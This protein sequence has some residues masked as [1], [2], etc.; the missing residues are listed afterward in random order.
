MGV[1]KIIYA[2]ETLIDLTADTVTAE[3]LAE[4][5]TAHGAD[6]EKIVGTMKGGG[7]V[8]SVPPKDVNFWDY[9]GTCL[10]AYTLAEAQALTALPPLPEH[11][12]LICQG[13]NWTLAEVK[14]MDRRTDVGA[15]Y[16]TDDGATRLYL[17]IESDAALTIPLHFYQAAA[18]NVEIDWG[19]GTAVET[20]AGT[21][22]IS[23]SHTYAAV[24]DYVIRMKV[25]SGT[26]FALGSTTVSTTVLGRVEAANATARKVLRKV[27]YGTCNGW[28]YNNTFY[29]CFNLE[30]VT[31]PK[32]IVRINSGVFTS[33]INLKCAIVP[34]SIVSFAGNSIWNGCTTTPIFSLP[35]N[36]TTL[37]G[38]NFQNCNGYDTVVL[39]NG[40]TNIGTREFYL[41][42]PSHLI[43]P[44]AL[45][46]IN[47]EAFYSYS[48]RKY[49]FTR[50]T[51]VPTLANTNA[52]SNIHS[53]AKILVPAAS[54]D[55]WKAATNWATYASYI[56]GV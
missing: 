14:A 55:E 2:G 39:P 42:C 23:T 56:V 53:D 27:E 15:M 32:S 43:F 10:Y 6:G 38:T 11:E 30:S 45:E 50:C 54:A 37:S 40:V 1:N 18:N 19:D 22:F 44:P 12:G 5:V 20:V 17:T 51:Q 34:S 13:W 29:N 4:G 7:G 48:C 16:I 24:G 46:T 31:L 36:F 25:K 52:F 33:C 47:A 49:D 35:G 3:T 9:D 26:A 28:L 21:G 41:S 8:V